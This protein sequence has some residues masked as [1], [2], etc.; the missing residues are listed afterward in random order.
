MAQQGFTKTTD[1]VVA[2]LETL[3]KGLPALPVNA[4]ELLV[5][6]AP[7]FALIFG[8]LGILGSIAAFGIFSA[9]APFGVLYGVRGAAAAGSMV[10]VYTI[11]GLVSSALMLFAF[12]GLRSRKAQGWTLLF[13]SEVVSLVSSIAGVSITGILFSLLGFYLLFQ[14]KSYYK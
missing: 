12:P 6:V 7:Y 9:I 2:R 10:I 14:V 8:I 11:V 4:K 13:W 3:N 1:Q 5:T